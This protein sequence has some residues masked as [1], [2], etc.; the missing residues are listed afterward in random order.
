M[1]GG[2]QQVFRFPISLRQKLAQFGLT[3]KW[4][5]MQTKLNQ[6]LWGTKLGRVIVMCDRWFKALA[7]V[8]GGLTAFVPRDGHNA[9]APCSRRSLRDSPGTHPV[10]ITITTEDFKDILRL[11]LGITSMKKNWKNLSYLNSY[12]LLCLTIFTLIFIFISRNYLFS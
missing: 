12:L 4:T 1:T 10:E 3:A 11:T 6:L 7:V 8:S 2:R 9:I 5:M